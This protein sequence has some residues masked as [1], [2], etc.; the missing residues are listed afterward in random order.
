MSYISC[1]G[2][3]KIRIANGTCIVG[4]RLIF[5]F[6]GLTVYNVLH[7]PQIFYNLMSIS[8]LTHELNSKVMFLLILFR[9]RT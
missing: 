1:V 4:K 6:E 3:E 5:P 2:N 8:K 7:V 9:F